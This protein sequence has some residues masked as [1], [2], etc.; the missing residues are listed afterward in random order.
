MDLKADGSSKKQN[1]LN[2][3]AQLWKAYGINSVLVDSPF[4]LGDARRGN[5]RGKSEH[6]TRVQ[7]VVQYYKTQFNLPVWIFGHSMGTV[8][9]VQFANQNDKS[10]ALSGIIIAG[11]H[12]GET[13]NSNFTKPVMAI[14]H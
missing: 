4:D 14:H 10:G 5:I 3:S 12:I 6:L 7:S 11:T 8:T 1:P 2:R 9:A 13:L